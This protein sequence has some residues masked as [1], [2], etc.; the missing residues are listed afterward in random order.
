[1]KV[2]F[3]FIFIFQIFDVGQVAIIHKYIFS[4]IW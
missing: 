4:Q 3:I 2:I 1:M